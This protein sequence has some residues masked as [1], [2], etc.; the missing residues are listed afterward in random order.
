MTSTKELNKKKRKTTTT[1]DSG[2]DDDEKETEIDQIHKRLVELWKK[3]A[4]ATTKDPW[5][6]AALVCQEDASRL[7][8]HCVPLCD[9]CAAV[10]VDE[11][12]IYISEVDST[13]FE[14]IETK[15]QT[16]IETCATKYDPPAEPPPY[17]SLSLLPYHR[18]EII[19][20]KDK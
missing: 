4:E 19:L 7:N 2:G 6:V 3:R 12:M 5:L 15:I 17:H 8:I 11:M 13:H 18:I 1:S 20:L 10:T 9:L 14:T 16:M